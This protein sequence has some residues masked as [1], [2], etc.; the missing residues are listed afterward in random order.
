MSD[1]VPPFTSWFLFASLGRAD[2]VSDDFH[3]HDSWMDLFL[4]ILVYAVAGLYQGK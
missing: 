2:F 3:V 4:S 1:G